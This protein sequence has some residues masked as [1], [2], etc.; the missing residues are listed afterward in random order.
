MKTVPARRAVTLIALFVV[1]ASGMM[2]L[3]NRDSLAPLHSALSS[4]VDPVGRAFSKMADTST[5]DSKLEQQLK[6]VTAERDKLRAENAQL[7]SDKE[8]LETLRKQQKVQEKFPNYTFISTRVISSD[9]SG[10]QLSITIDKGTADGLQKGMAV[11]DPNSYIGQITA[12]TEHSAQ[13]MLI[14]DNS[15]SVG[16]VLNDTRADGVV[17]G[18][19]QSGGRLVMK[20]VNRDAKPKA[21]EMVVTSDQ[22]GPQTRGVPPNIPIGSVGT[23]AQIDPQT[24]ELVLPV[25]PYANFDNLRVVWVVVASGD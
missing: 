12:V 2:M 16:A 22:G 3:D 20:H 5:N 19:W 1:I 4:V 21:G 23:T 9:P 17:Y 25:Y 11:T 6:T 24:D 7:T 18:Q 14:I 10:Q 13:V 8:E 15:Q